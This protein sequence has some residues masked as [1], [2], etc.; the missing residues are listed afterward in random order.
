MRQRL[1]NG[2]LAGVLAAMLC[3]LAASVCTEIEQGESGACC[4]NA[5][6]IISALASRETEPSNGEG[7]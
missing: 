1:L 6:R 4:A 5:S 7:T 2:A 3:L